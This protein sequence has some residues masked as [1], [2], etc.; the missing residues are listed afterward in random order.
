V[1]RAVSEGLPAEFF[2][3]QV[4]RLD[5]SLDGLTRFDVAVGIGTVVAA[6]GAAAIIVT[7]GVATYPTAFA[8]VLVANIATLALAGALWRRSRPSSPFG[9]LLL[10][11][12]LLVALTSLSGSPR[13]D[14]YFLGVLA[15]WAAGLEFMPRRKATGA[16][17]TNMADRIGAVGGSV[18]VS[19]TPGEGTTVEGR[20]ALQV[21]ERAGEGVANV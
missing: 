6:C 19:S 15:G 1:N 5:L 18:S 10:A 4:E 7:G 14:V 21:H 8:A 11:E 3:D 17:L 9:A 16:G 20:L 2:D 12:G 13:P